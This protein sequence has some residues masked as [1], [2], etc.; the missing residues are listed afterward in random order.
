MKSEQ[1][2]A[3]WVTLGQEVPGSGGGGAAGSAGS[4][5]SPPCT[6]GIT[7][8]F[9]SL[10]WVSR[11]PVLPCGALEKVWGQVNSGQGRGMGEK[12]VRGVTSLRSTYRRAFGARKSIGALRARKTLETGMGG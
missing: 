5:P 2:W 4:M 8:H 10:A 12:V 6:P 1:E 11:Q 7:H 3:A 9:S